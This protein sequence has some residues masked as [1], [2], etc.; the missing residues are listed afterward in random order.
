MKSVLSRTI[1]AV[2]NL[3]S[4]LLPVRAD[5]EVR[6]EKPSKNIVEIVSDGPK[7]WKLPFYFNQNPA[8]TLVPVSADQS[9]FVLGGVLHLIDTKNGVVIGRWI[10]PLRIDSVDVDGP[11]FLVHTVGDLM[12]LQTTIIES[13]SPQPPYAMGQSL[14]AHRLAVYEGASFDE[15]AHFQAKVR[16]APAVG[17]EDRQPLSRTEAERLIV[18]VEDAVRRNP[19]QPRFA[20]VLA[21]LMKD[22]GR[23][24]ADSVFR[25]AMERPTNFYGEIFP[26]AGDLEAVGQEI[27][28]AHV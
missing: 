23:K 1:L 17:L 25:Q 21:L 27:G 12:P 20:V 7:P 2:L 28:R 5:A 3:M 26:I 4:V 18:D 24:E 9:L 15:P 22:A 10:F 8:T 14:L 19:F 16:K 13:G 11:K 6:L